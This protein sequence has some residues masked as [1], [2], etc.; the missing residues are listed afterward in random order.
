MGVHLSRFGQGFGSNT[1]SD[2]GG[3]CSGI[4]RDPLLVHVVQ[5]GEGLFELVLPSESLDVLVNG[6]RIFGVEWQRVRESIFC[7]KWFWRFFGW[8]F[9]LCFVTLGVRRWRR[10]FM[11]LDW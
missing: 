7:R 2:E 8:I 1:C 3:K 9:G 6:T 5:D 4:N 10:G 11:G